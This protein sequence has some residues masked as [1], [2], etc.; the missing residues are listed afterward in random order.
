MFL[1]HEK[2][3]AETICRTFE[4]RLNAYWCFH[5]QNRRIKAYGAK[6]F[7]VVTVTLTEARAEGLSRLA[8]NTIPHRFRKFFTFVPSHRIFADTLAFLLSVDKAR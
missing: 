1:K 2:R 5:E 4:A 7:R 8:D 3:R 6:W